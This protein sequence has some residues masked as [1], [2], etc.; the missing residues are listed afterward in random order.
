M[1]NKRLKLLEEFGLV[2]RGEGYALTLRGQN[3]MEL[4]RPLADWAVSWQRSLKKTAP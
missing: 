4:H 3:L 2:T 1:L